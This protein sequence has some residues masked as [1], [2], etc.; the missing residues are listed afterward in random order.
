MAPGN[1]NEAEIPYISSELE[2]EAVCSL[3]KTIIYIQIEGSEQERQS[4]EVFHAALQALD[5]QGTRVYMID[6]TEQQLEFFENWL[7][8]QA[9]HVHLFYTAGY[10]E[11]LFVEQGK[12][13]DFL[14]FPG[15]AGVE[16]TKAK[17]EAWL[18][19]E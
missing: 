15:K 16:G 10:G 11:I 12:V 17:I 1:L 4:R 3:L 5:T 13:I 8:A 7:I 6:C 18:Q 2:F 14:N 9:Q 19:Q